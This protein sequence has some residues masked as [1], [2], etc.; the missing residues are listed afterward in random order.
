[1]QPTIDPLFSVEISD[2]KPLSVNK[3]WQGRRFKSK[4]YNNYEKEAMIILGRAKKTID[5]FVEIEYVFHLKNC[6]RTDI[7]NLIKPLQDIIV[8][9]GYISDDRKIRKI[10]AEK[11][12]HT[13]DCISFAIYKHTA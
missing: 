9:C 10:T 2:F 5:E 8:K 1:M 3:A 13:K 11:K 6:N 12:P 4:D 7:D